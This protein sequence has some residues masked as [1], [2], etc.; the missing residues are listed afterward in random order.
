MILL[1]KRQIL[2]EEYGPRKDMKPETDT[3]HWFRE[4]G[5]KLQ[6]PSSSSVGV[7]S[8]NLKHKSNNT[9]TKVDLKH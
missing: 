7:K 9:N 6:I 1:Y 4:L 5:S 2:C 8:A 3:M